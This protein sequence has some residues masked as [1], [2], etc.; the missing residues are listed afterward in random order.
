MHAHLFKFIG[1]IAIAR[2][3]YNGSVIQLLIWQRHTLAAHE[4]LATVDAIITAFTLHAGKNCTSSI[5]RLNVLVAYWHLS[6][7][8]TL[9]NS[10]DSG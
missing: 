6:Q 5:I 8:R 1:N 10:K 4:L 3:A 9:D 7:H 2:L